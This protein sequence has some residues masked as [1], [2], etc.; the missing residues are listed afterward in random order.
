MIINKQRYGRQWRYTDIKFLHYIGCMFE[1]VLNILLSFKNLSLSFKTFKY[2]TDEVLPGRLH[3]LSSAHGL[4]R[5]SNTAR[6]YQRR[7]QLL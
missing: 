3:V 5:T 6:D 7:D 2:Q 1:N 4:V